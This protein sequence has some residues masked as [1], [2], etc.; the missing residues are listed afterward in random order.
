[1][2]RGEPA[3]TVFDWNFSTIHNSS[4]SFAQLVGS[5]LL[6]YFYNTQPG[7]GLLTPFR[8]LSPPPYALLMLAFTAAPVHRTLT[9]AT[10]DKLVGSFFN[11][12]AVTQNP[13]RALSSDSLYVCGFRNYF[14]ALSGYF[15][16]FPHGTCSLSLINSI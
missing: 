2:F 10:D 11:R 13:L 9:K 8:V 16:P 4:P 5:V 15:S 6:L 7:H 12:H 1:M 14:I 3:I